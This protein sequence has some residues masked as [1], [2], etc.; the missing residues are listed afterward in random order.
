[1]N[2]SIYVRTTLE[3]LETR[4]SSSQ[5]IR[6]PQWKILSHIQEGACCHPQTTILKRPSRSAQ[7]EMCLLMSSA[8]CRYESESDLW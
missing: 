7:I 3:Y 8:R 1:M 2:V 4:I 6:Y 5:L